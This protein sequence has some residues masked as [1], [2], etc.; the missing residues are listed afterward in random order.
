MSSFLIFCEFDLIRRRLYLA[1]RLYDILLITKLTA[2]Y[3]LQSLGA[4]RC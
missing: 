1:L 4:T 2:T 3:G